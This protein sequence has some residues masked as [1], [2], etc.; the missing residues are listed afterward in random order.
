MIIHDIKYTKYFEVTGMENHKIKIS[1]IVV[2]AVLFAIIFIFSGC[3]GT[4]SLTSTS[5]S[6]YV[7]ATN[8]EKNISLSVPD[9]WNTNDKGIWLTAKIGTSDK[10][11]EQHVVV[12]LKPKANYAS[13]TTLSDYEREMHL[14]FERMATNLV[15]GESSEITIDG[16]KGLTVQLSG[17]GKKSGDD[18][19]YFINLLEDDNNFYGII[20]WTNSNIA[21]KNKPAIMDIINSFETLN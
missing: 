12:L 18:F 11:N 10:A 20:G 16:L 19:V 5:S 3:S 8:D 15:W 6:G 2:T 9:E 13:G 1:I 17:T 21:E 4:S 14:D 7:M